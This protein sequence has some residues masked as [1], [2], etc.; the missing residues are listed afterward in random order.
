V[1]LDAENAPNTVNNFVFLAR[2]GFYD[3]TLLHRIVPDFVVQGGDREGT[4]A[5]QLGYSIDD[6]NTDAGFET[7]TVAMANAGPDTNGSQ[8]FIVSSPN[9]AEQ[10]NGLPNYS[11]F[12]TVTDGLDVVELLDSFGIAESGSQG[13][14]LDAVYVL[15]VTITE[16]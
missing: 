10:L 11:I 13:V 16:S 5:G 1:A 14:P 4:G 8:F 15:G 2:D 6:E 12:G 3:G 7:G 9:G